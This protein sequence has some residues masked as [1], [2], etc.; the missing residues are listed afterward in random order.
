VIASSKYD[1]S[2][3]VNLVKN[4]PADVLGYKLIFT[5]YSPTEDGKY[6]FNV[7]IEKDGKRYKAAPIMYYSEFNQGVMREPDIVPFITRDIYISP[8]SYD[9]GTSTSNSQGTTIQVK[10]GETVKYGESEIEFVSF[11]FP[12]DAMQKMMAGQDFEMGVKLIVKNYGSKYEI[13]P[14]YGVRGGEKINEPVKIK[15][16]NIQISLIS[17][18]ADQGAVTLSVAPYSIEVNNEGP[19]REILAV[20]ASIKPFVGLVWLGTLVVVAGF[21]IAMLRRLKESRS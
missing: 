15:D 4:E 13:E 11:N 10:K 16:A 9:D 5:G 12:S 21:F 3:D 8:I 7:L 19:K 2:I 14:K 20:T 17:M 18:S 6:A 1:K